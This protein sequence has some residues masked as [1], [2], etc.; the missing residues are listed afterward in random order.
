MFVMDD[1]LVDVIESIYFN[2]LVRIVTD[3]NIPREVA[4]SIARD[5]FKTMRDY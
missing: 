1:N 4:L 3:H 2:F 5:F